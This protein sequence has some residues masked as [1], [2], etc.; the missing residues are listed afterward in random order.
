MRNRAFLPTRLRN[1]EC[2]SFVDGVSCTE[3]DENNIFLEGDTRAGARGQVCKHQPSESAGSGRYGK[4][5]C[6]DAG[7][8]TD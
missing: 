7:L 1:N 3:K 2:C 6:T 4:I 5:S 8:E